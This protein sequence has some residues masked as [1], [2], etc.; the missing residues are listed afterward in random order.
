M[1]E[2]EH[3]DKIQVIADILIDYNNPEFTRFIYHVILKEVGLSLG[4][5]REN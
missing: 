3:K 2:N 4:S 1:K 5:S